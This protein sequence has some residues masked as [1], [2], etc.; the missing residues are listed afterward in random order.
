MARPKRR[1]TCHPDR[2]AFG[3]G[4]CDPCYHI[5]FYQKNKARWVKR[6]QL[7]RTGLIPP[8]PRPSECHPNKP[9]SV[10]GLCRDCA[11]KEWW[12][13]NPRRTRG[14]E[15][16]SRY[17]ITSD[18]EDQMRAAQNGACAICP[19][20]KLDVDHD[21]TTGQVRGLLC[22]KHNTLVGFLEHNTEQ[23]IALAKEYLGRYK[24]SN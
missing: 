21:H 23:E 9:N 17:G 3:H 12:R 8:N 2:W 10:R 20:T 16:K 6:A 14:Y 1:A 15:L 7:V 18:T 13:A 19:A 5:E 22:R 11:R 4:L 24:L